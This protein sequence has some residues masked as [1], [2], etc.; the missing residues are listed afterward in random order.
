MT[1]ITT[2]HHLDTQFIL[3]LV[4]ASCY[5]GVFGVS[6]P[7]SKEAIVFTVIDETTL[8]ITRIMP[9]SATVFKGE[10]CRQLLTAITEKCGIK[11]GTE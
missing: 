7:T 8:V 4:M 11:L 1:I 5:Q 6:D 10:P 9:E 3:G 2:T